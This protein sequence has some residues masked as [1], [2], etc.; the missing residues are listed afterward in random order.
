MPTL[1]LR[2]KLVFLVVGGLSASIYVALAELLH[3]LGL[4]P[5]ASSASAYAMCVPIG[6]LGHRSLTFR[7]MRSHRHAAIAYPAV[8]AIALIIAASLTFI[9][10]N[11]FS[12][13]STVAFFL[14]AVSAASASYL[15]QKR[16]VF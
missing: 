13:P 11:V 2:E 5:T 12:L 1:D 8:Q 3:F 6:Y 10:A 14:A 9:S 4:S 15:M 7:S 16:W